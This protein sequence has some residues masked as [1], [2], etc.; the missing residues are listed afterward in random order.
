MIGEFWTYDWQA[1]SVIDKSW[2]RDWLIPLILCTCDWQILKS[3][4][5]VF[6]KP[7][8]RLANPG[9]VFGNGPAVG[10]D[11]SRTSV[12]QRDGIRVWQAGPAIGKRTPRT[13]D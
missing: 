5:P 13:S 7:D 1:G 3:S 8:L 9:H 11:E 2:T 6:G 12:W 10:K 4:G